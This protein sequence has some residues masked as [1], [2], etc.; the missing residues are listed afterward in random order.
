MSNSPFS[1]RGTIR[2]SASTIF[3][4]RC[5]WTRPMDDT[6]I[7]RGSSI[8]VWKLTGDV[9][10]MPYAMVISAMCISSMTRVMT[11]I[12][13][14]EP[15]MM[16]VRK[17]DRSYCLKSGWSRMAMNMVGT[18]CSPVQRSACTVS[19]TAFGSKPSPGN[20]MAAPCVTQARLP[21]TMPKQWYR[22]TGMH[23]RSCG[24]RRM[25][26]PMKKPLLRILW[27]VKVAPFGAPVVPDVN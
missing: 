10:V 16:P 5:G 9:S 21:S 15:A 1:P 24:V 12:G 27:C 13:H 19:S 4:S 8:A 25:A 2:P 26:S 3:T 17:V 22:G 20:T 18:P 6:R 11:S 7:S 23:K 14:G